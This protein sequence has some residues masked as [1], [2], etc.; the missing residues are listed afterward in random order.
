ME[1]REERVKKVRCGFQCDICGKEWLF[2]HPY[3]GEYGGHATLK[4]HWGYFSNGKDQ[5]EHFCDLC[6]DCFDKVH[7]FIEMQLG[8]KVHEKFYHLGPDAPAASPPFKMK[9]K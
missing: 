8:G 5:T 3:N 4:G 1:I 9:G 6:E 2:N 7:K